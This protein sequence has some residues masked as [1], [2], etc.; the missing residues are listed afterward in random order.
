G[1]EANLRINAWTNH[2][3]GGDYYN[4][5]VDG[6]AILWD[7]EAIFCEMVGGFVDNNFG[8]GM[9]VNGGTPAKA[10]HLDVTS[11]KFQ[12]NSLADHV[13]DETPGT[14]PGTK[15]DIYVENC[16]NV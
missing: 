14:T 1:T 10:M 12:K 15:P 2:I 8:V 9:W 4:A 11:V 7:E 6:A 5:G 3:Y 16:Q 13:D